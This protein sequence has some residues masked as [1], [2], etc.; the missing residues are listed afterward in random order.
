ASKS[1]VSLGLPAYGGLARLFVY[2]TSI[3][4]I[5]SV[6]AWIPTRDFN[7]FTTLGQRTL[8]VYLL[9]G[10]F[11][12]LFR[13]YDILMV[14]DAYHIFLLTVIS[15]LIVL[16]L[17]SRPVI[18]LS[19]PIVEGKLLSNNRLFQSSRFQDRIT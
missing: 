1:Y 18:H 7:F 17:S 11:V 4:M 12:Q 14:D 9:H 13:R 15:G 5:F 8:Y 3:I 19:K 16:I 2:M 6:L 10:F